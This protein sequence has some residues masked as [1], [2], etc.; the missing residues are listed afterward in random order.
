[1]GGAD[2]GIKDVVDRVTNQS[3]ECP[4]QKF[5][6]V[7]YSQGGMVVSAA[8]PK[9]PQELRSK[10]VAMVLYG[11]GKGD[12]A[13]KGGGPAPSGDIKAM[14]LANCAPGDG[15]SSQSCEKLF[16][17]SPSVW[18]TG[19]RVYCIY[20]TSF[21]CQPRNSVA[22]QVREVYRERFPW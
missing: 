18:N 9:I 5:A 10:V 22:C 16:L 12:S 15:V 6:I 20:W 1:M 8:A 13:G 17:T 7:G 4:K 3:K 14:T 21:L 2:I 11:A 19:G